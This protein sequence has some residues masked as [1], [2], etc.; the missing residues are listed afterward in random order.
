MR[1]Q[2]TLIG[3]FIFA[4]VGFLG[5]TS[6][7]ADPL[8]FSN[9]VALQGNTRVDLFSNPGT[10]LVGPQISFLVDISGVLPPGGTD[11]LQI[12]FTEA[13]QL[14]V[15][16]TFRV[17]LFDG[18]SLPYSQIFSFTFQNPSFQGTA[19]TLRLDILGSSPDFV[20]PAG[21]EAGQRV[22]SFTYDFKGVQPVPEPGTMALLAVG[23]AGV[24]GKTRRKR[25]KTK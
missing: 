6:A 1:L 25:Q 3:L 14:P 19:T 8:F 22:D 23:V 21:A 2:K 11:T 17:P 18:L 12:T 24:L 16:Q 9:V 20:I 15:V 13:G 5:T 10:L 7:R 4:M